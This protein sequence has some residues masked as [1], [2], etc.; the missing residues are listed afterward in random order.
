[1]C[2]TLIEKLL[3]TEYSGLSI[4][5]SQNFYVEILMPKDDGT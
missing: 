3:N 2:K 1:M 5:S 4:V